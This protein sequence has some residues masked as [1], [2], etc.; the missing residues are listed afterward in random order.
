[1]MIVSDVSRP[2]SAMF[3]IRSIVASVVF[4][5]ISAAPLRAEVPV[6]L[7][8]GDSLSAA[9]AIPVEAGWVSLLQGQVSER[10]NARVVNASV[11]GETTSGGLSR[12]PGLLVDH[13]PAIVA[14]QLGANDGLRGL[15]MA[16]IKDNLAQLVA[17]SQQAGAQVLLIGIELPVNYGPRYRAALRAIYAELAAEQSTQLVPFLLEGVALK[18]GLILD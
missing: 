11:S 1:R 6:V 10:S 4:C 18:S 9:H 7:V 15:P 17:L 8:L 5:L 14:I 2:V 13:A 12:L 16:Q 3:S